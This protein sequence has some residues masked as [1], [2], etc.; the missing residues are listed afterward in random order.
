MVPIIDGKLYHFGPRGLYNGLVLLGDD[1][2]KSYWD[3]ITGECVHGEMKGRKMEIFPIEHTNVG[4]A[5]KKN[6][7]LS[8]ALSR[9]PS[10]MRMIAP[11]MNRGRKKG[12][13]PPGFRK[14]MGEVDNR[15]SEMTSGLGIMMDKE[16][17]FYPLETIKK[18]GGI[19]KDELEGNKIII[20]I[21]PDNY[22]PMAFYDESES[23]TDRP[24]QLFTRWYGFSLTFP[25][26]SIYHIE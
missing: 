23:K 7:E 12:F 18:Q 5:L 17:K 16:K 19:I 15:L 13:L 10:I 24:M 6:P 4:H 2:T 22:I 20:T 14:T 21:D 1:E 3:H 8:I 9:P 11:L 25:G 26:C